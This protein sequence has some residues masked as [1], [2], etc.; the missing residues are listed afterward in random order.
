MS[1]QVKRPT[2]TEKNPR[3]EELFDKLIHISITY[4]KSQHE[5]ALKQIADLR[6]ASNEAKKEGHDVVEFERELKR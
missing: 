4:N 3:E 6:A 1:S 5:E 2:R